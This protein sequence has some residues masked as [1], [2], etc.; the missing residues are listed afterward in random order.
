MN[1]KFTSKQFLRSWCWSRSED[2]ESIGNTVH[3]THRLSTTS[4]IV[5]MCLLR[6]SQCMKTGFRRYSL[7]FVTLNYLF[8]YN[9]RWHSVILLLW[10]LLCQ[11]DWYIIIVTGNKCYLISL[12]TC[13]LLE[14]LKA[15]GESTRARAHVRTRFDHWHSN[16]PWQWSKYTTCDFLLYILTLSIPTCELVM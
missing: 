13:L 9:K 1:F 15:T 4:P 11:S 7:K 3:K 12:C 16:V 10:L 6:L 14:W 5:S 8:L 2:E